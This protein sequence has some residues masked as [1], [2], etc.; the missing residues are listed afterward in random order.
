MLIFH[1]GGER[2]VVSDRLGHTGS[3]LPAKYPEVV[4]YRPVGLWSSRVRGGRLFEEIRRGL[5]LSW[6]VQE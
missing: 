1:R 5:L 6:S 4:H 3:R 2:L